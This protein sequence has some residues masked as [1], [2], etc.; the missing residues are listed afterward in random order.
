MIDTYS[1]FY[2]GWQIKS[3]K[4]YLDFDE[5]AGAL[6]AKIV[7]GKYTLDDLAQAV[8]DALNEAGSFLYSVIADRTTRLITINSTGPVDYLAANGVNALLGT[9]AFDE[10]GYPPVDVLGVSS[11]TSSASMGVVYSPQYKL[12]DYIDQQDSRKNRD[13]TLSKSASGK[14]EIQ[15]FGIDRFFEFSIKFATNIFQPSGGPIVNNQNGVTNLRDFMQWIMDKNYIE[16]IPDPSSP[17]I[18]YR[19]VLESAAGSSDGMGY[20]LQEQY[21]RGL[22]GYWETGVLTFRIIED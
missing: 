11:F 10:L 18:Y 14:V 4:N 5:G 15:S 21:A 13:A 12:Q 9:S 19:I 22:T 20:K 17:D 3:G 16:F 8:E 6:A 2:Y 1:K 7:P